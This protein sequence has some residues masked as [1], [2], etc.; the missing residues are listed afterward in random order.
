VL[1][2]PKSQEEAQLKRLAKE[3]EQ[4]VR[5][6]ENSRSRLTDQAF[7]EKAPPEVVETM[8]KK[9]ADYESQLRKIDG[10]L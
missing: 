9:L 7:L 3:R 4:L 8:R 2:L 1:R 10:A 6:I 5:N